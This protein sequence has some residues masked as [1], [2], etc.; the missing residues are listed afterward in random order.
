MCP[1]AAPKPPLSSTEDRAPWHAS[2]SSV[3]VSFVYPG[4]GSSCAAVQQLREELGTNLEGVHPFTPHKLC[5]HC[6]KNVMCLSESLRLSTFCFLQ[7]QVAQ[8]NTAA[9][10]Q[11]RLTAAM[12]AQLDAL[13]QQLRLLMKSSPTGPVV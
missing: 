4:H 5:A 12:Q 6:A 11:A 13:Q 1:A 8:S 10:E 7:V 9:Q 3:S 2:R